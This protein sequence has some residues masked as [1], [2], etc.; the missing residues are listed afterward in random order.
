MSGRPASSVLPCVSVTTRETFWT[1]FVVCAQGIFFFPTSMVKQTWVKCIS[2][3]VSSLE[4]NSESRDLVTESCHRNHEYVK[5]NNLVEFD[6]GFA[7]FHKNKKPYDYITR[8]MK[9]WLSN[10]IYYKQYHLYAEGKKLDSIYCKQ[11][12]HVTV[13]N[14]VNSWKTF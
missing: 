11:I 4:I 12:R 9:K 6:L 13:H 7:V 1:K 10:S 2:V 3:I 8:R 14:I 5:H